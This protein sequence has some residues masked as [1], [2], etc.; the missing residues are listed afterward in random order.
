[1]EFLKITPELDLEPRDRASTAQ[2]GLWDRLDEPPAGPIDVNLLIELEPEA[3]RWRLRTVFLL[4]ILAH[5]VLL[6]LLYAG[7][8]YI[9]HQQELLALEAQNKPPE[10]MFLYMP[11]DLLKKLQQKPKTPIL[12]DKDRLAQGKAPVVVPRAPELPYSK[13]NTRLPEVAGG[14]PKVTTPPAPP[15]QPKPQPK[16]EN[17]NEQAKAAPKP[18]DDGI[19]LEDVPK[20]AASPGHLALALPQDDIQQSLQDAARASR[21]QGRIPGPGDSL[22]QFSNPN[23]SF[24][25]EGPMILSDT[26]GVDFGPYL[27]RI[28]AV[29]RRN[30][31]TMMPES[32]RLGQRG[33]VAW[34]FAIQKDGS[35]PG[36]EMVVGSGANALDEAAKSAIDLSTPFPPLPT[37]FKGKEL[38]LRFIFLYNLGYG[39]Q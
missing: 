39:P 15:P 31:Y 25:L 5:L 26:Q 30:W 6:A 10:P 8:G 19:K 34:D 29:V 36:L 28:V 11:P 23:S 37:E 20:P 1:L 22:G 27:A 9:R 12:S 18:S 24:S 35:V 14:H 32:A 17:G 33:R 16:S 2:L 13:G 21:A 7:S 3:E 4:S 38:R